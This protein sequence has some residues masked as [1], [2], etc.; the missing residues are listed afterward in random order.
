MNSINYDKCGRYFGY[1]F[2]M[3]IPREGATVLTN[4]FS[5]PR[6]ALSHR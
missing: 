6:P 3:L 4:T 2:W 1:I 5:F